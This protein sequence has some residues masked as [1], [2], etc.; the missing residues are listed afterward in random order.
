MRIFVLEDDK[1]LAFSI[2]QGLLV[3]GYTVDPGG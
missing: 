3:A 2:K 1:V